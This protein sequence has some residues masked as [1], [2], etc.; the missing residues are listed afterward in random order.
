MPLLNTIDP[1]VPPADN[2]D[3]LATDTSPL[4]PSAVVPLLRITVPLSLALIAFADR[5]VTRP[6]DDTDPPPLTTLT[7]PPFAVPNVV[8]PATTYTSPPSPESLDPTL[9]DTDPATPLPATPVPITM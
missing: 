2:V 9:T 7:D 5:T 8:L 1:D 3:P 6:D 4:S